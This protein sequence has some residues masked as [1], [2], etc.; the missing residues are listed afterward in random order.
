MSDSPSNV[1]CNEYN[2]AVCLLFNGPS[3]ISCTLYTVLCT[4]GTYTRKKQGEECQDV[5]C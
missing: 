3:E 2:H 1:F 4:L 5:V